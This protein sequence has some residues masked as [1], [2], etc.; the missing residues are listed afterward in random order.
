MAWGLY[1]LVPWKQDVVSPCHA[2]RPSLPSLT[3]RCQAHVTWALGSRSVESMV[4]G[5]RCLGSGNHP[6]TDAMWLGGLNEK[7]RAR[8]RQSVWRRA[9]HHW[10]PCALT[11]GRCSLPFPS[12]ACSSCRSWRWPRPQRAVCSWSCP[13]CSCYRCAVRWLC[14]P[15]RPMASPLTPFRLLLPQP[16][17]RPTCKPKSPAP[18]HDQAW[19]PEHPLL[20]PP[21]DLE[22]PALPSSALTPTELRSPLGASQQALPERHQKDPKWSPQHLAPRYPAGKRGSRWRLGVGLGPS[23]AS[24]ISGGGWGTCAG[25]LRGQSQ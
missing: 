20:Q 13:S 8:A 5:S 16:W 23:S 3:Q 24:V 17:L 1:P 25:C 6:T 2:Q 14:A 10:C 11:L 7:Q 22:T 9:S 4:F 15:C 18:H 21:Q 12:C 19:R